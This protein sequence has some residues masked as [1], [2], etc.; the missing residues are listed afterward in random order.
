[1]IDFSGPFQHLQF[2]VG[3]QR[4][5]DMIALCGHSFGGRLRQRRI[6][7]ERFVIGFH[8]PSFAIDCGD[9]F[10]VGQR[11]LAKIEVDFREKLTG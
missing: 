3:A 10:V 11:Q 5:K 1:M 8:V 7:L 2:D 4:S 9:T 6:L